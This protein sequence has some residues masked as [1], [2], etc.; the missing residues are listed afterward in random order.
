M[1]DSPEAI[2]ERVKAEELAKGTDPRVAEGRAKAAEMRAKQGLPIDPQEAWRAKLQ[3]EGGGGTTTAVAA[4]PAEAPAVAPAGAPEE[5]PVESPPAAPTET[6]VEEAPAA[7]QPPQQ[8]PAHALAAPVPPPPAAE[9]EIG[10]PVEVSVE[11]LEMIAG[12]AVRDDRLPAWLIALLLAI[13]LWALS[14]LVF[15]ASGN[16]ANLSKCTAQPDHTFVCFQTDTEGEGA[17]EGH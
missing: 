8:E 3:Q 4:P 10:Q 12:I 14:Y 16:I 6:A 5:E 1:G 15:A 9:L 13:T 11:G 2:R 17:G 7:P